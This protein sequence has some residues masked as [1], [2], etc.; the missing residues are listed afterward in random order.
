M[1][2]LRQRLRAAAKRQGVL[3]P[4]IEKDYALSYVIVGIASHSVLD[5][6]LVF[7]AYYYPY[8][9]SFGFLALSSAFPKATPLRAH[10]E[11]ISCS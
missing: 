10:Y 1:R 2:P 9:Y 5:D 11:R 7:K 8:L 3:Q 4:I 6:A